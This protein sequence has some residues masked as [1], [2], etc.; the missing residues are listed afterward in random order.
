M[1]KLQPLCLVSCMLACNFSLAQQPDKET[2]EKLENDEREAI[3]KGDTALLIQL[4]SPRIVVHN[5][6]NKIAKFDQI[7]PWIKKEK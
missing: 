1:K 7:N 6:E 4:M 2:L 3:L 5:P